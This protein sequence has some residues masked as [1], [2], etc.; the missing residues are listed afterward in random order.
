MKKLLTVLAC[1]VLAAGVMTG[2]GTGVDENKPLSEVQTEAAKL[3][4]AALK[5]KIADC[6][7]FLAEKKAELEKVAAKIKD[8]P[9]DKILSEESKKLKEQTEKISESIRKVSAQMKVYVDEAA[10]KAKNAVKQ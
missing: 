2:C 3:D 1:T 7:K 9:L 5:A 8:I 10:A 4:E 6:E